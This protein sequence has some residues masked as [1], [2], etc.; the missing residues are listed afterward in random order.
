MAKRIKKNDG[1]TQLR[2]LETAERLFAEK[3]F[4]NVSLREITREAQVNVAAVKYHFGSKDELIT[5][6]EKRLTEPVNNERLARLD[7]LE[8]SGDLALRSLLH[9][10][11][12]PLM[13][14]VTG[15]AVTER[16][17]GQFM[18]RFLVERAQASHS[19]LMEKFKEVAQRY[20]D[21]LGR[22]APWLTQIEIYWRLDFSYGVFTNALLHRDI[23]PQF[24]GDGSYE[25]NLKILFEEVL[26]F[27]TA[28]FESGKK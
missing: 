10:F 21:A 16:L 17:Y 1:S 26:D 18:A 13:G 22:A 5:E 8:K 28:G 9:A 3:G 27:C 2:L 12:E 11:M 25:A 4:G 14:K 15:S 19:E 23:L 7:E 24:L 6:L 20:V